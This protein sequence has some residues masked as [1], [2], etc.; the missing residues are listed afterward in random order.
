MSSSKKT[1]Y[2]NLS[3][4]QDADKPAWRGDYNADMDK[5]DTG[6]QENKTNV[7]EVKTKVNEVDQKIEDTRR[8]YL[9][10]TEAAST[11]ATKTELAEQKTAI[12][13]DANN[14]FVKETD[15][16]TGMAQKA[17]KNSV[18]T[19]TESDERFALKT[20]S[21][22]MSDNLESVSAQLN[23]LDTLTRPLTSWAA[24]SHPA[25]DEQKTISSTSPS[26]RL[27]YPNNVK[28]NTKYVQYNAVDN[29]FTLQPGS[30]LI[31]ARGRFQNVSWSDNQQRNLRAQLVGPRGDLSFD[32]CKSAPGGNQEYNMF[33][34]TRVENEPI[35]CSMNASY[36]TPP[37]GV[38]ATFKVEEASIVFILLQD[39]SYSA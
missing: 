30:Y 33:A 12:E 13:N 32:D 22:T 18:Y 34:V 29:E 31:L 4:F 10:K 25:N 21:E 36:W 37:S 15:Y 23:G 19:R 1:T 24:R 5:I 39:E 2:F 14:T 8:D 9:P 26:R 27:S 7:V 38:S 20:D 11:Y 6:L 17:D 28:A 35:V 3:Q 16:N